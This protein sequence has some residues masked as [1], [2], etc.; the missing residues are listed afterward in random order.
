MSD[1]PALSIRQPW[2]EM[3]LSGIKS[4]ELRTWTTE[5]RGR[6]WLHTGVKADRRL[7]DAFGYQDLFLG[8]YIGVATIAAIVPIDRTRWTMWRER[9]R[10]AG[11]YT[12]GFFGW[13]IED[14]ARFEMPIPGPGKLGLFLPDGPVMDKLILAAKGYRD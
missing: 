14:V 11:A 13:M 9:H 7:L 5:Y 10:D 12:P 2:A 3:I 8:G 1:I 6:F 4:I